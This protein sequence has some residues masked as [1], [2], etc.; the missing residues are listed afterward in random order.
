MDYTH[1]T[2]TSILRN[3]DSVTGQPLFA[4]E[5]LGLMTL[6]GLA[7]AVFV[8]VRDSLSLELLS[9]AYPFLEPLR[10][11]LRV[12]IW[13]IH[14]LLWFSYSN[15]RLFGSLYRH[16]SRDSPDDKEAPIIGH[17]VEW[18]LLYFSVSWLCHNI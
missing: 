17:E 2:E 18:L 1:P 8:A 9:Y 3:R 16:F 4:T 6:R 10:E 15:F 7:T 13:P 12:L 14:C 11:P 5:S